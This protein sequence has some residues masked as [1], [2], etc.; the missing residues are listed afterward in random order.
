MMSDTP[1]TDALK[2][3]QAHRDWGFDPGSAKPVNHP[4]QIAE[5]V[6]LCGQ[7]ER[8]LKAAYK[9]M[10]EQERHFDQEA[11]DIAAEERWKARQGDEYGSY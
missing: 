7:L 11:R 4:E 10:R 9:E 1:R 8:E 3:T 5:W 2:M 6:T